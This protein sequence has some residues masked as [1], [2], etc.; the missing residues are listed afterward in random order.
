MEEKEINEYLDK[1]EERVKEIRERFDML[2]IP[3]FYWMV[4]WQAIHICICG[5]L[6][7]SKRNWPERSEQATSVFTGGGQFL[8]LTKHTRKLW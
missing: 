1:R 4:D 7:C 3:P 8:F 2:S 5:I 6:A